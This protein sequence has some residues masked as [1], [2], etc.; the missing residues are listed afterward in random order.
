MRDPWGR[1]LPASILLLLA[2]VGCALRPA[3]EKGERKAL[4]EAGRSW[5]EQAEPPQLPERPSLDEYLQFAFLSNADLQ[6]QYWQWAAAIEQ[7][8]QD[9]SWP[10]LAIPF[11]VMFTQDSMKLWNRTTLGITNDP[12]S[13]IP[14][15]TKLS[16]AGRRALEDARS[17]GA[18]FEKAKFLLQGRVLSTWYDL[19][20]LAESVRIKE[21]NV[22]LLR[23]ISEQ[24]A[25]RVETGL[26]TQTDFLR[27]QTEL[28][29]AENDLSNLNSQV[30]GLTAKFNA[31]LGREPAVVVPLPDALPEP[32]PLP[33][34]DD[35]LIR[36]GSE[37][38]ADLAA[39]SS[40]I[41]GRKEALSLARQAWLPDFSLSASIQGDLLQVLGGMITL[42]TQLEGI[43]GGIAQARANLKATE[44]AQ[45]QYQRDLAA[46][47]I[48]NLVVIR[49]D[50]RQISLFENTI[51]PRTEQTVDVARTA[52]SNN[53][54]TFAE[55]LDA[56]RVLLDV[57]LVLAQLRTEREKAL[58]AIE[59]WSAV[60]VE[61]MQPGRMALRAVGGMASGG[62]TGGPSSS[63][64]EES[65]AA[66]SAPARRSGMGGG[67]M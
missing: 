31:L 3:G 50:E 7:V 12:T 36:I 2:V 5:T 33:V 46:S 27:A 40:E 42:P 55:L 39:L 32:R 1:A 66:S 54:L 9:S 14:F 20:L 52:Y 65:N 56:Q 11:S 21:D 26:S 13:M 49:N 10:R 67:G 28:D 64:M 53:R 16:T 6:S 51:L 58:A 24:S 48:L 62:T 43:K 41:A 37:R 18:R 44:A 57:R 25:T 4:E 23:M 35:E 15:P 17:A 61:T 34:A 8:P 60:D 29:L 30:S 45:V 59:T 38:S 63:G 22:A 47:F 19:A